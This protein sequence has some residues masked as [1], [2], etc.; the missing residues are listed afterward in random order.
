[1]L[2][3][4]SAL[5]FPVKVA[6][7]PLRHD[8]KPMNRFVVL[9]LLLLVLGLAG[10]AGY[11]LYQHHIS[12]D[13]RAAVVAS[14]GDNVSTADVEVFLR[15]AKL[16][17]RT[18][19]DARVVDLLDKAVAHAAS[20]QRDIRESWG[21]TM[22]GIKNLIPTECK[23]YG[24]NSPQCRA[25]AHADLEETKRNRERQNSLNAD[26]E[27]EE[28]EAKRLLALLY[29]DLGLPMPSAKK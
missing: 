3:N 16:A 19:R 14:L 29:A 28:A 12:S 27:R 17:S 7:P 15:T 10:F 13:V 11:T 5:Y 2:K 9:A 25:A 6:H 4:K 20:S 21:I 8:N 26:A 1:M 22:Q 24:F 23:V 18:K